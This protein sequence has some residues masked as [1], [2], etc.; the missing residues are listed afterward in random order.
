VMLRWQHPMLG[1]LKPDQ[2]I[3]LAEATGLIVPIGEWTLRTACQQ[4]AEW[5]AHG[6]HSSEL[7]LSINVSP[8][9]L[10]QPGFD[11]D[12]M[13][14]LREHRLPAS[15]LILEITESSAAQSDTES[16]RQLRVLRELGVW[17]AI[18]DFGTGYTSLAAL[19][20]FPVDALKIDTSFVR[21]L[22]DRNDAA[23]AAAAIALAKAL[24]LVVVAEGVENPAQLEFLRAQGCEFWQGYLCC[25]P[26]PANEAGRVVARSSGG[27]AAPTGMEITGERPI[28]QR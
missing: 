24:G 25:P 22:Q 9:Q 13:R 11:M 4:L 10:K 16:V 17:I 7:R 8:R 18:D 3:K 21:N 2:F 1:M 26:V 19:R 5:R 20:A 12:V 28:P 23:I 27:V 15:A 6:S 14:M